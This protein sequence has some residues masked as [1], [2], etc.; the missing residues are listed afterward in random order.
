MVRG[1]NKIKKI[2]K[3]KTTE[4]KEWTQIGKNKPNKKTKDCTV[5]CYLL[6]I[7]SAALLSPEGE[8]RLE[9][10][11]EE[12]KYVTAAPTG[13]LVPAPTSLHGSQ[14][15]AFKGHWWVF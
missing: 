8:A 13:L 11:G 6:G 4:I 5:S 12:M 9:P 7:Q 14:I 3:Q 1:Y 10:T 2:I 15:H